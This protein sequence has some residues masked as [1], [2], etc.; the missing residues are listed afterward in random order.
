MGDLDDI[1]RDG[2][3]WFRYLVLA[4]VVS[5]AGSSVI[6]LN[7]DTSDRYKGS[8]AREDFAARDRQIEAI[9][10]VMQAHLQHSATYS[11]RIDRYR[12][13]IE[14]LEEELEQHLRKTNDA[15]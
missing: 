1:A 11:D 2:P 8:D 12:V 15:R 13:R 7:K 10:S 5:G 6:S 14:H 3:A 9:Q 4:A